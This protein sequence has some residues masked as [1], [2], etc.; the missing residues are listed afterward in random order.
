MI[1]GPLCRRAGRDAGSAVLATAGAVAVLPQSSALGERVRTEQ[2]R[3]VS[4][5]RVQKWPRTPC[6]W[7]LRVLRSPFPVRIL[8]QLFR[9][10][11]SELLE[12]LFPVGGE[13][14]RDLAAEQGFKLAPILVLDS[15]RLA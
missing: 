11:A 8:L 4:H 12:L 9:Q 1:V 13:L 14:L 2:P 7:P 3:D 15:S 6:S 10:V 5:L